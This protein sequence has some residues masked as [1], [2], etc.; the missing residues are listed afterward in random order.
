[1]LLL[2]ANTILRF[3]N[4]GR[5]LLSFKPPGFFT[6]TKY[7]KL[8]VQDA[9]RALT[10]DKEERAGDDGYEQEREGEDERK[11]SR[12]PKVRTGGFFELLSMVDDE[13]E[14]EESED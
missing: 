9:D 10:E 14:D 4:D 5:I 1:M 8:R 3:A 11:P 2:A 12:A 6:T 13:E 7:E